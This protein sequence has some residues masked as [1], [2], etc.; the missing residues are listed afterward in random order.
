MAKV[1]EA[2]HRFFKCV[3]VELFSEDTAPDWLTS[4]DTIKGSTMDNRWFWEEHVLPLQVGKSV[5]TDFH[6]IRR[7]E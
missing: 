1:F 7:V 5:K 2:T 4:A 6:I 3:D